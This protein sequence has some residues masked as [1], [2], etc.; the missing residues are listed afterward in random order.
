MANFS[1]MSKKLINKDFHF[2]FLEFQLYIE[3]I[4]HTIIYLSCCDKNGQKETYERK[5]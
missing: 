4:K 2:E 1:G 3:V 5:T